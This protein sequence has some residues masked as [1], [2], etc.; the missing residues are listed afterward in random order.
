[1]TFP[2]KKY[3]AHRAGASGIADKRAVR[4]GVPPGIFCAAQ[5]VPAPEAAGRCDRKSCKSAAFPGRKASGPERFAIEKAEREAT[6]S[7]ARPGVSGKIR[8]SAGGRPYDLK[9]NAF[10]AANDLEFNLFGPEYRTVI[11][12]L[13]QTFALFIDG[14]FLRGA[15]HTAETGPYAAG[16]A[17]FQ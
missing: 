15:G 4:N 8:F 12:D 1:M 13:H 6:G 2:E 9:R 14:P 3:T 10:Q 5:P 7:A 16:H 17:V 11:A